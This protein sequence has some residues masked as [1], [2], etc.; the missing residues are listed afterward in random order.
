LIE[1]GE[2]KK[3]NGGKEDG[4]NGTQKNAGKATNL[5][6]VSP[7]D[8]V[9]LRPSHDK[10]VAKGKRTVATRKTTKGR[11]AK[12]LKTAKNGEG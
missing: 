12:G 4:R 8:W 2:D 6:G 7:D 5:D 10:W 1:L 9:N 11:F 3:T